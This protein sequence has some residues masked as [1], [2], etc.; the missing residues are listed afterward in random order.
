M[1]Q[2]G[3]GPLYLNVAFKAYLGGLPIVFD[4]NAFALPIW[5]VT[6]G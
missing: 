1:G 5:Y 2:G 3:T 6:V 4:S